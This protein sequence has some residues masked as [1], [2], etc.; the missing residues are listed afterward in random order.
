MKEDERASSTLPY[1]G[2]ALLRLAAGRGVARS[3]VD[4]RMTA[5]L[6]PDW[7]P[8]DAAQEVAS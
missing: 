4:A 2:A 6:G 8:A 3:Q 5:L 1:V 7:E